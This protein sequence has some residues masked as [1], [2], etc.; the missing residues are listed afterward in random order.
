MEAVLVERNVGGAVG[1]AIGLLLAPPQP[2]TEAC[3]TSEAMACLV[4]AEDPVVAATA[5][6]NAVPVAPQ[7]AIVGES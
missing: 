4:E 7:S 2:A 6:S 5:R 3:P 1:M